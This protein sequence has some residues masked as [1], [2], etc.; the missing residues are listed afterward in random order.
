MAP[1]GDWCVGRSAE[2]RCSRADLVVA[3]GD[4]PFAIVGGIAVLTHVQGH[5]VTQDIVGAARGPAQ[6]IREALLSACVG[7]IAVDEWRR[8]DSRG[9][10]LGA[11][12]YS[13]VATSAKHAEAV[14]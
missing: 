8:S 9:D 13:E 11:S 1:A 14:R 3:V 12:D 7:D 4:R 5:R 6:E 2:A 10:H